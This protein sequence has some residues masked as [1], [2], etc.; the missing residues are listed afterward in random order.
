MTKVTDGYGRKY[1]FS[2]SNGHLSALNVL[3]SDNE[4]I[5]INTTDTEHPLK[6]M[7][8]Y[9]NNLLKSVTYA[10]EKE[11]SYIYGEDDKI[12]QIKNID[13]MTQKY[14]QRYEEFYQRFCSID[15]GQASKR[16]C[17]AVFK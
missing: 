6:I 4:P 7:Y 2:Y 11:I 17:E 12:E 14:A 13:E 1:C 8:N 15:D 10:D 16:A 9:S 3:N 5:Y